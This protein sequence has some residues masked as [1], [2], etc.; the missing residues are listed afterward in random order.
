MVN[1]GVRRR[2][3]GRRPT[4]NSSRVTRGRQTVRRAALLLCGVTVPLGWLLTAPAQGAQPAAASRT[5]TVP[6]TAEAWYA[7]TP[8]DVCT[9]P[10]GCLPAEVPT[11]PYP[12][13]TL[14]VGLAAG[15][16][17]ARTYLLPGVASIPFGAAVQSA[18]M[19]LPV[20]TGTQ[21]GTQAADT[22]KIVACLSTAPF[23]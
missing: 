5:V 19:T 1:S 4:V 18:V 10:L 15:Q 8:V 7:A 23:Q 22:A 16:E 13:Q 11:S 12:D 2:Q 14:H 20:A 9:T 6:D 17:T 21:D 3:D